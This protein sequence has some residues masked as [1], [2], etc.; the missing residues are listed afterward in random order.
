VEL[1]VAL[2]ADSADYDQQGNYATPKSLYYRGSLDSDPPRGRVS[3]LF[4]KQLNGAPNSHSPL[5]ESEA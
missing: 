1:R 2:I 4:C 3:K 5:G